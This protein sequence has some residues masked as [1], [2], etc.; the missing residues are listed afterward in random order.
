MGN[1]V[2]R[3]ILFCLVPIRAATLALARELRLIERKPSPADRR[4]NEALIAPE[5]RVLTNARSTPLAGELRLR[6][7]PSGRTRISAI[8]SGL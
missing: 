2:F 1:S 4:I 3:E 7:W 8:S 5:G 6:S